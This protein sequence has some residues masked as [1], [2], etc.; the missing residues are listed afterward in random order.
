MFWSLIWRLDLST[1]ISKHNKKL[2]FRQ[3]VIA[4]KIRENVAVDKKNA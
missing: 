2:Y 3:N 1:Q 4:L